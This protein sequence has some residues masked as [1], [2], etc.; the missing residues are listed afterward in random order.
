MPCTE[1]G[2]SVGL[3]PNQG[4][5][6]CPSPAVPWLPAMASIFWSP[7]E[8]GDLAGPSEVCPKAPAS[9]EV[10]RTKNPYSGA[11]IGPFSRS[12]GQE[13]EVAD[14]GP[15]GDDGSRHVV[16]LAREGLHLPPLRRAH[17]QQAEL[18]A[19]TGRALADRTPR[20]R[21]RHRGANVAVER[22]Q[23]GH[24]AVIG[25]DPSAVVLLGGGRVESP[26]DL[27][28]HLL[29]DVRHQ[30]P[31]LRHVIVRGGLG[32]ANADHDAAGR[33]LQIDRHRS[34]HHRTR[35]A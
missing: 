33:R 27:D 20:T 22:A 14:L 7:A 3:P 26:F 6:R 18:H 11:R 31:H 13:R 15:Q 16:R 4:V 9:F 23:A 21:V 32:A 17:V 28:V 25:F 29:P 2:L 1:T 34:C 8:P 10:R 24:S 12:A 35:L 19:A 30:H 5:R